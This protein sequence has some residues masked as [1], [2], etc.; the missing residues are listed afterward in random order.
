MIAIEAP[1]ERVRAFVAIR[2][3]TVIES[4]VADFIEPLRATSS[5]VHWVRREQLHVTLRFLGA[6]V[7]RAKITPFAQAL[8]E[9]TA[10]AQS[11][12]VA[13]RG[14][15]GFPDLTRPKIVWIGLV[16][17]PLVT[18]A[19]RV[20][21]LA[22]GYG[23]A[24]ERRP[25]APHLTIGRVRGLQGWAPIRTRLTQAANHEFGSETV[26]EVVVY[27]SIL[28]PEG[29]SYAEIARCRLCAPG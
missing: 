9:L 20:E 4:A 8:A 26:D 14:T 2:L 16:S 21:A 11:F 22:R 7:S 15:G 23:F 1:P 12:T 17:D 18:L 19:E 24:A 29:A 3:G 13:A 28:R 5:G 10:A 27:R 6:E 25:F